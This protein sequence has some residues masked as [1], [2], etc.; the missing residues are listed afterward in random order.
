MGDDMLENLESHLRA[1]T[2]PLDRAQRAQYL[3]D[4]VP[5]IA[6]RVRF[7]A[8]TE[9]GSTM[10]HVE[11]AE[12]LGLTRARVSQILKAGPPPERALLAPEAGV[13]TV[14][15]VQK[16]DAE[17]RQRSILL[18]TRTAF[19]K[20]QKLAASMDIETA[21]APEPVPM[22]GH[23]DLNRSNLAVLIGPRISSFVAQVVA[24]DPT[25][26]WRQDKQGRWYLTDT[27]TGQEFHSDFDNGWESPAPAVRTCIAQIGRVRRPDGQGT[28]LYLGGAH[29]PGTSGAV[30]VFTREIVNIW[31]LARRAPW[32]AVV[33]TR[34]D[35]S[36]ET[37]SADLATP[38]YVHGKR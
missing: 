7:E 24:S 23:I 1:I 22:P 28:F 31:N 8:V 17:T 11:I 14:A 30:E 2:D 29:S 38:I 10:T 16:I 13:F 9:L 19:D 6:S 20:L 5:A 33:L 34:V 27:K 21:A 3:I 35:E 32:S 12:A 4:Q 37:I 26:K 25:V 36:G 18:S 15:V